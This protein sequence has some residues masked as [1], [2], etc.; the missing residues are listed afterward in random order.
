M[1]IKMHLLAFFASRFNCYLSFRFRR[2]TTDE[3][4]VTFEF[5]LDNIYD[6]SLASAQMYDNTTNQFGLLKHW[7]KDHV[8]SGGMDLTG[9]SLHDDSPRFAHQSE[10]VC[11]EGTVAEYTTFS[12]SE[13]NIF[14]KKKM[15]TFYTEPL[16]S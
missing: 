4:S 16:R 6:A 15:S 11:E 14:I 8:D 3:L 10:I 5:V 13:I 2:Q 9:W 1:T 7:L 12:C